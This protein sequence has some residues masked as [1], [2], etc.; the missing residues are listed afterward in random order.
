DYNEESCEH[1]SIIGESY[2]KYFPS[3]VL[4][5][6]PLTT[7][8][9]STLCKL[10]VHVK[11]YDDLL[12]DRVKRL[13]ALNISVVS[14][15]HKYRLRDSKFKLSEILLISLCSSERNIIK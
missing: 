15:R 9:S 8:Y 11:N 13:A 6:L 14:D 1:L 10:C 4:H 3:F 7:C 2:P 5:N 12:D